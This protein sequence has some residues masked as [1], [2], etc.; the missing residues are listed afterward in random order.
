MWEVFSD[1]AESLIIL[2]VMGSILISS[3]SQHKSDSI[4]S[5]QNKTKKPF[6]HIQPHLCM[7]LD[8]GVNKSPQNVGCDWKVD[9]DELG[10]LMEAEQ[11]EVVAQ[12]HCLDGILLLLIRIRKHVNVVNLSTVSPQIS[13][14]RLLQKCSGIPQI[15]RNSFRG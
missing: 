6:S 13:N 5:K 2:P 12:L 11:G 10:L 14:W 15:Y 7:S 3:F 8:L 9:E 1:D 4:F